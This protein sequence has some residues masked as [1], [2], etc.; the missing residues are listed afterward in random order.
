MFSPNVFSFL[1]GIVVKEHYIHNYFYFDSLIKFAPCWIRCSQKHVWCFF[2]NVTRPYDGELRN[3]GG[4]SAAQNNQV[5]HLSF[6]FPCFTFVFSIP[7]TLLLKYLKVSLLGLLFII[8]FCLRMTE[9]LYDNL[10]HGM[11]L[12]KG[13]GYDW[14]CMGGS[15]NQIVAFSSICN[16]TNELINEHDIPTH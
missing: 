16:W 14:K 3:Y 2:S 12:A 4:F 10:I 15:S 7:W 8:L 13:V 11:I 1:R 6:F 5:G 9:E